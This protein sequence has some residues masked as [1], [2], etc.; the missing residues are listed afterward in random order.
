MSFLCFE[1]FECLSLFC[2]TAPIPKTVNGYFPRREK[3]ASKCE[4]NLMVVYYKEIKW[5]RFLSL[6]LKLI[7]HLFGRS[8]S[9]LKKGCIKVEK[10]KLQFA[11]WLDFICCFG[12]FFSVFQVE[13]NFLSNFFSCAFLDVSVESPSLPWS[14]SVWHFSSWIPALVGVGQLLGVGPRFLLYLIVMWK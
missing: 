7:W 4:I 11:V 5:L 13:W 12:G 6:F 9:S 10:K 14:H 2:P 8:F 1:T 3:K